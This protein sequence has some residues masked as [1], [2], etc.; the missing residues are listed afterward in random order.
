MLVVMANAS[1]VTIEVDPVLSGK[2][3]TAEDFDTVFDRYVEKE[4]IR[5]T[6]SLKR[7]DEQLEELERGFQEKLEKR[8][9]LAKKPDAKIGMTKE[10]VLNNTN[11]GKPKYVNTTINAYGTREQWVYETYQYLYFNNGKL[12]SIQY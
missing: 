11:W 9:L 1:A 3:Q 5:K 12:T 2:A 4:K 7:L 6:E 10:Q 8:R